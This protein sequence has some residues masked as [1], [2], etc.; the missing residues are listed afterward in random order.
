MRKGVTLLD[1]LLIK[2]TC[3]QELKNVT[4]MNE[5][6]A[7][8]KKSL[9]L[10]ND[11][12]VSGK[13]ILLIDDLYRSGATLSAATEILYEVGKVKEVIVLTMTKTRSKR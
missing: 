9:S 3:V 13:S 6:L 2:S 7:I 11:Y 12:D 4:D 1:N 8:L 10:S 5:R